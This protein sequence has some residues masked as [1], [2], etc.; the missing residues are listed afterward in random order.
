MAKK[1]DK[2]VIKVSDIKVRKDF[3]KVKPVVRVFT[4]KKKQSSKDAC[5]KGVSGDH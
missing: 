3:G 5:R 2:N 4:D 1:G